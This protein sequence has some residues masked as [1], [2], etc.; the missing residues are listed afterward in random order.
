MYGKQKRKWIIALLFHKNYMETMVA[1]F[2]WTKNSAVNFR[3]LSDRNGTPLFWKR[4]TSRGIRKWLE[5]SYWEF[6]FHVI[7]GGERGVL[8]IRT[9]IPDSISVIIISSRISGNRDNFAKFTH[10]FENIFRGI[11]V[12][13]DGIFPQKVRKSSRKSCGKIYSKVKANHSTEKSEISDK[14]Y[15]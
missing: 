13:S 8:P 15:P 12:P 11:S 4:T 14:W 6:P 2:P 10:S 9:K 5:I 7:S 3:K 1:Q